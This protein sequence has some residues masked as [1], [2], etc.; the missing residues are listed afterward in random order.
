MEV[1]EEEKA[2]SENSVRSMVTKPRAEVFTLDFAMENAWQRSFK[3]L[4]RDIAASE[5]DHQSE[6]A[7][8]VGPELE[9]AEERNREWELAKL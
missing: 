2:V 1:E 5:G 4:K 7:G 9:D 6:P 8:G 3:R